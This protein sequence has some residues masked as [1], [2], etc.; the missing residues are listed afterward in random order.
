VIDDS[1]ATGH[2][3]VLV[4]KPNN[5]VAR[6]LSVTTQSGASQKIYMVADANH[7]DWADTVRIPSAKP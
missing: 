6:G 2:A 4:K 3:V 5:S 7:T 1:E